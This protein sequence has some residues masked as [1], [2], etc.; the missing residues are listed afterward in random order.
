[1]DKDG[2]PCFSIRG[3]AS[4]EIDLQLLFGLSYSDKTADFKDKGRSISA[5]QTVSDYNGWNWYLIQPSSTLYYSAEN[6][7]RLSIVLIILTVLLESGFIVLL[8]AYNSRSVADLSSELENQHHL[9]SALTTMVE[10]AKPLVSESYIRKVMEGNITTNEQMERI[11]SELGLKREGC[12]YQVLYIGAA[13][14]HAH[15]LDAEAL[16]LCIENH[17]ILV[18]EALKRYFP[19]T[20][21]I[22]KPGDAAFACLIAVPSARSDN[23]NTEQNIQIFRSVHQELLKLYDIEIRGGLGNI[24]EVVPYI[25]KSY[26]EA[27]NAWS[28]TTDQRCI[29]SSLRLDSSTD[30]YY[31]PES[32][33]VQL[34]GFI[35]TGS[36]SQTEALFSCLKEENL[37]KRTLSFT[38][39]RWLVSDIRTVLFRKRL[40]VDPSLTDAPERKELLDLIDRQFENEI[41]LDSLQSIALQLCSFYGSCGDSNELIQKIQNY[42]NRNYMDSSLSLSK[43]SEEF[44]ISENYFSFLFKKKFLKI[45]PYIWKNCGWQRQR[46]WYWNPRFP[47][48]SCTSI[49][50][51][52]MRLPSAGHLRK[53]SAYHQKKCV[54]KQPPVYKAPFPKNSALSPSS[55]SILKRRLYFATRSLRL[56]APVL[57]CPVFRATARSAIA[58]SSVSPERWEITAVYPDR[59]ASRT[60]SSV[61]EIVPI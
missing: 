12:R 47:F 44:H 53:N 10:Q 43:I 23:E 5:V 24:C 27:H 18:Q 16:K 55:S 9:A 60:A 19:D 39:L 35:S 33:A 52:T 48:L 22:Y 41:S 29:I 58:V 54:K 59:R 57:I 38:Q 6:Y 30:T 42:L 4:P 17:D 7:Q 11:T 13:P 36:S 8:T 28:M 61:S 56:G 50:A 49:R 45:F 20:G 14:R 15:N 46:N 25:W 3:S 40:S 51:T 26:Q 21:H 32:L 2:S 31:F 37:E 34:S 1:M